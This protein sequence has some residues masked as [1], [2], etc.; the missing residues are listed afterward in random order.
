MTISIF[1]LL[2]I[3]VDPPSSHA[4]GRCA[5]QAYSPPDFARASAKAINAAP[6]ALYGQPAHGLPRPRDQ[7]DARPESGH[8]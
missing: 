8:E 2:T 1:D 4:L 3:G 5:P 7:D 6:I